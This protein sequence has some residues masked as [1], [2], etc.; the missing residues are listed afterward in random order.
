MTDGPIRVG[1]AGGGDSVEVEVNT[2]EEVSQ[3]M[4]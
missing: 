1:V 4:P 3:C 2:E